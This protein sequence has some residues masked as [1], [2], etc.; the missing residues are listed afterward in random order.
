MF[1]VMSALVVATVVT[2]SILSTA[3]LSATSASERREAGEAENAAFAAADLAIHYL[4]NPDLAPE[5]RMKTGSDGTLFYGGQTGLRLTPEAEPVTIDVTEQQP[6]VYEVT[7]NTYGNLRRVITTQVQATSSVVRPVAALHLHATTKLG[8]DVRV[9]G[10]IWTSGASLQVPSGSSVTGSVFADGA[11]PPGAAVDE[12]V[13]A[14]ED[15]LLVKELIENNGRY[16][17]NGVLRMAR[18]ITADSLES[19]PS[20]GFNN[21]RRVYYYDGDADLRVIIESGY[22]TGTLVV[23][24]K[25]V[26]FEDSITMTPVSGMP[27]LLVK[28]HLNQNGGQVLVHG[29]AYVGGHLRATAASGA[30]RVYGSLFVGLP[31]SKFGDRV[32]CEIEI[33]WHDSAAGVVPVE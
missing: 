28:K 10:D 26:E 11:T 2:Y 5:A 22:F 33:N 12:P 25:G 16:T 27:T 31:R 15:L 8:E 32:D 17:H 23:L 1:L 29:V 14:F 13:P 9:Q 21:P 4:R 24:N 30:L 6:G 3:T 19:V 7:A 20:P 18:R